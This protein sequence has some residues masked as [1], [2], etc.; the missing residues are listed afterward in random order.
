MYQINFLSDENA[1]VIIPKGCTFPDMVKL[2][3]DKEIGEKD[4]HYP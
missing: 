4:S 1:Q 3:G 2:K